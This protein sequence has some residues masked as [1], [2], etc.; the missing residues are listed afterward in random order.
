M[1]EEWVEVTDV[2]RK[3]FFIN[4]GTT[5]RDK[6]SISTWR[7]AEGNAQVNFPINL[8]ETEQ[9]ARDFIRTA[10]LADKLSGELNC[11]RDWEQLSL[12]DLEAIAAIVFKTTI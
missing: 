9:A 12:S 5:W 7:L 10:D 4:G 1:R 6:F 2:G 3:Y 11:R 8:Y